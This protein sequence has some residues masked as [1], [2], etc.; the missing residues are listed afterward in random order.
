MRD[1]RNKPE[2]DKK[3]LTDWNSLISLSFLLAYKLTS[4]NEYLKVAEK[5]LNFLLN[6]MYNQNKIYHR[7]IEEDV[8]IDG[9]IDD[10]IFLIEA[11]LL[12]YEIGNEKN[13]FENVLNLMELTLE[14]FWD[15]ENGGFYYTSSF[16][17]TVLVRK[18][19]FVDSIVPSANSRAFYIFQKL[20]EIT[21]DNKFI[22]LKNK[23]K[24]SFSKEIN[25]HPVYF[26]EFLS[27][28][29]SYYS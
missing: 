14:Y 11:L 4:N 2:I 18:K 28:C 16:S 24:D 26:T 12:L 22:E 9:F 27:Y 20:Y 19:E 5:N 3:I 7:L 25:S 8:S 15:N 21:N 10:Y 29:L 6:T 1:R 17:E 23:L 13:I